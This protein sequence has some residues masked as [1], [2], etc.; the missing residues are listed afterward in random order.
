MSIAEVYWRIFQATGNVTA[1]MI[2]RQ[3]ADNQSQSHVKP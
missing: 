2:Y 3:L 1:Y